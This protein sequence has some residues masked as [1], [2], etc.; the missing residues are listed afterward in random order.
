M[1]AD[2]WGSTPTKGVRW[3][4]YRGWAH[5]F[6]QPRGS[7]EVVEDWLDNAELNQPKRRRVC[8]RVLRNPFPTNRRQRDDIDKFVAHATASSESV[9]TSIES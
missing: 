5:E 9:P 7:K 4:E 3:D 6:V 8:V 2:A 1:V